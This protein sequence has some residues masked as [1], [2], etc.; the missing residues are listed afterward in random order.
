M[1]QDTAAASAR[2]AFLRE[3]GIDPEAF[4][5]FD[6]D[7]KVLREIC[8]R[9]ESNTRDLKDAGD[10]FAARL[11]GAPGVH[12]VRMR[13]KDPRHLVK[14]IVRDRLDVTTETY[15]Q[16]INDLLGLRA[17][18]LYRGDWQ[19]I[20]DFIRNAFDLWDEP[21]AYVAKGE[22]C[23]EFRGAGC[24]VEEKDDAYRSVHY[25]LK[26][27]EKR[28]LLRVELQVRTIFQEAWGEISRQLIYSDPSADQALT[29]YL[30]TFS[31]LVQLGDRMGSYA[32]DLAARLQQ[33]NERLRE[34]GQALR[35][36][37]ST[38]EI[39][40]NAK[41]DLQRQLDALQRISQDV[42]GINMGAGTLLDGV[43]AG[44]GYR[45]LG[46]QAC[47]RCGRVFMPIAVTAGGNP[48]ECPDCRTG[49]Y[50]RHHSSRETTP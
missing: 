33:G 49:P 1:P 31:L 10:Y 8:A 50:L 25:H 38:L 35:E 16:H 12:S 22:D 47:Q 24:Q 32:K 34:V 29:A 19:Q 41:A 15:E 23:T 2:E 30:T 37:V 18:H 43:V 14:K 6:R 9:H 46:P 39:T 44:S 26:F 42:R 4:K 45:V 27:R 7:W 13:V 11:Q 3:C 28:R 40:E 5:R 21:T 48:L 17:L 36:K 20:H